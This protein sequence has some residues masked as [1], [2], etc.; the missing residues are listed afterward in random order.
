MKSSSIDHLLTILI[1]VYNEENTLAEILRRTTVL[2]I[3]RY[4]VIVVDDASS[5]KSPQI[6]ND[7]ENKFHSESVELI[8]VRHS[9]NQGKGSAIQTAIK[10]AQGSYFVIQDADLEYFPEDLPKLLEKASSQGLPVVYGSRFKGEINGMPMPN[11]Y[12]NRFYNFLLRRMYR[13]SIT[14]MHTCYKLVETNLM[15]RLEITSNGFG[16]A[17]ELVSKILRNNLPIHEAPIRFNGR[18]KKDGK[19]IDVMDG[20][21]CTAKLLHLRFSRKHDLGD[22]Q[23]EV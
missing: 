11:F 8:T 12:A 22:Y 14:D 9:K 15:R 6:I 20:I 4:E 19:K 7:F 10:L 17:T 18:T 21:E 1:P 13:T 2:P 16:Y 23:V 3:E 5:D